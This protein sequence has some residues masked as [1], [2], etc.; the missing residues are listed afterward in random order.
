[1]NA[2]Q[3]GV[4][5]GLSDED[6]RYLLQLARQTIAAKCQRAHFHVNPPESPILNELRG[7]FVTLSK[8]GQLRGCIGYV[9]GVKPLYQTIVE[10]AEAAAFTD[11]RF[12]AVQLVEVEK[13]EIEISVLTP[14]QRLK[15]IDEI[16]IGTHGLLLRKGFYQGLLL[17]QV[18]IQY[19]WDRETF[20]DQTCLK[21]GL[22]AGA[23]REVACEICIFSADIFSETS[24]L[25]N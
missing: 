13:I 1:M 16:K 22:S 15:N 7:A 18:A 8:K 24:H 9:E 20:L 21:A 25:Q 5:L 14:L 4:S 17:P 11:P 19:G 3:V 6:K 2:D 10:M 12:P 23:W